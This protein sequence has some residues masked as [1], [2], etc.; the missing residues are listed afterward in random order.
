MNFIEKVLYPNR[1]YEKLFQDVGAKEI[2]ESVV[3]EDNNFSG[4]YISLRDFF[5]FRE[6]LIN[7][8]CESDSE[9]MK[10]RMRVLRDEQSQWG[11]YWIDRKSVV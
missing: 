1:P 3:G 5:I 8:L 7:A 11:Y 9:L 6:K 10:N 2:L 4:L